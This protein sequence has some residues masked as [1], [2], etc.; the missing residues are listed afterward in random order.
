MFS[1]KNVI[2]MGITAGVLLSIM[3][4]VA[5]SQVQHEH[6]KKIDDESKS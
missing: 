1:K 6:E 5:W 3:G 4:V 2:Y